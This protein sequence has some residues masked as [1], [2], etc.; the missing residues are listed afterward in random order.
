[1]KKLDSHNIMT[2]PRILDTQLDFIDVANVVMKREQIVGTI[3]MKVNWRRTVEKQ[4]EAEHQ[5]WLRKRQEKLD[6]MT[7]EE[8]EKYLADE[9]QKARDALKMLGM[10]QTM[11][12]DSPYSKL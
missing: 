2:F 11:L 6:A 4:R 12:G 8:R 10:A 7:P 3:N 1:M 5:E 9:T